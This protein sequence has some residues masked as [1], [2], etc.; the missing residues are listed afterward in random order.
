MLQIRAIGLALL[1]VPGVLAA[2][3]FRVEKYTIGGEGGTLLH[4]AATDPKIKDKIGYLYMAAL[5]RPPTPAE[6]KVAEV[7]W[8]NH[9]G[10]V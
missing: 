9:R 2:Q 10:D 3:T 7:A 6:K 4:R 8:Q 1:V 5:G